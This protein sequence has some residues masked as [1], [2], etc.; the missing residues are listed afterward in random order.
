MI[1]DVPTSH[2]SLQPCARVFHCI[3]LYSYPWI[4]LNLCVLN[5]R[6]GRGYIRGGGSTSYGRGG[7]SSS[8]RGGSS[9]SSSFR[10]GGGSSNYN[11]GR[12]TTSSA[13]GGSRYSGNG[14]YGG[15]NNSSTY[16]SPRNS[17]YEDSDR[18]R[19]FKRPNYSND[20]SNDRDMDDRKRSR[21]E[22]CIRGDEPPPLYP[23]CC[24]LRG[25]RRCK[26]HLVY[27]VHGHTKSQSS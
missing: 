14:S 7:S 27:S 23:A 9:S 25:T 6:G 5:M 20:R 17:R 26:P 18:S 1:R 12:N 16:E 15:G 2:F 10:G 13:G 21:Y 3:L 11:S 8:Y 19:T 24:S 4:N 22:V